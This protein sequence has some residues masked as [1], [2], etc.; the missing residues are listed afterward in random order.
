MTTIYRSCSTFSRLFDQRNNNVSREA[1]TKYR[2]KKGHKLRDNISEEN[3][4]TSEAANKRFKAIQTL[5]NVVQI[6]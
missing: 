6:V 3:H 1:M 4:V 2:Q 5:I